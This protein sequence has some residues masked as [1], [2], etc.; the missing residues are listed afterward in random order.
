MPL[1]L[2]VSAAV[3]I[4]LLGQIFAHLFLK[5]KY[6]ALCSNLIA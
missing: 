3:V 6:V 1:F 5:G 4:V 2:F